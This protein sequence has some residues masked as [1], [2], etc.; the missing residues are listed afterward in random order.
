VVA[1]AAESGVD[2]ERAEFV[3]VQAERG[4]LVVL[5]RSTDMG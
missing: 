4:G 3:A 2:E 5:L 1:A